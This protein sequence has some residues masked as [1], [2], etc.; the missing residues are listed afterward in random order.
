M[1]FLQEQNPLNWSSCYN[2]SVGLVKELF[3]PWG[4]RWCLD[5]TRLKRKIPRRIQ[6]QTRVG[7]E[8]LTRIREETLKKL[9]DQD[10]IKKGCCVA[11][12]IRWAAK[13]RQ[14]RF[15]YLSGLRR[16]QR[17][18]AHAI[19]NSTCSSLSTRPCVT[20]WSCRLPFRWLWTRTQSMKRHRHCMF[21]LWQ[22]HH[23]QSCNRNY[24]S[25]YG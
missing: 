20:S 19:G 16:Q 17:E 12:S 9:Q 10:H 14:S 6:T 23:Y 25:I 11:V 21:H 8:V 15:R 18:E 2:M 7:F 24:L 13:L 1:F 3:L 4:S 22:R 5:W